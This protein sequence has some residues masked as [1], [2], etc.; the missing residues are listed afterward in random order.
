MVFP[1]FPEN[2]PA[3]LVW[4]ACGSGFPSG[5][6]WWVS[7]LKCNS[8]AHAVRGGG[9]EALHLVFVAALSGGR[10]QIPL[11]LRSGQAFAMFRMTIL[12]GEK[13]VEESVS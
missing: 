6:P 11:R 5:F 9:I 13:A 3:V 2:L 7:T 1:H 12:L 10:K 4:D 8:D